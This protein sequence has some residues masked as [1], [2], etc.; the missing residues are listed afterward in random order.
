MAGNI[1]ADPAR[2]TA[3]AACTRRSRGSRESVHV[4]FVDALPLPA[5]S[6]VSVRRNVLHMV[7]FAAHD[8]AHSI[9]EILCPGPP[10]R[11]D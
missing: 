1:G 2:V 5:V 10:C 6:A 11:S 7:R 3:I 8:A 9:E 4:E